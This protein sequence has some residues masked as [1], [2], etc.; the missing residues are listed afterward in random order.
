MLK[1]YLFRIF[2]LMKH[3]IISAAT[4]RSLRAVGCTVLAAALGAGMFSQAH[5]AASYVTMSNDKEFTAGKLLPDFSMTHN[6]KDRTVSFVKNDGTGKA[7]IQIMPASPHLSTTKAYAQNVM[8]SY[9]GWGLKA[10][11]ARRGFSFKYVDNAPCTG[12]ISYFDGTSYLMFGACG[13][14]TRE[15]MTKAFLVGKK[16]LN[17]DETLY[18]SSTPSAYY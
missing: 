16:E 13:F 9:A 7:F 11:I 10:Q 4:V 6:R 1:S 14:I 15:E 17:V 18:R 5:A 8:D 12:L 3:N 2:N